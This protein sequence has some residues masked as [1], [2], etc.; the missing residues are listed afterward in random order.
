M[1]LKWFSFGFLL[2]EWIARLLQEVK[3]NGKLKVSV[4][5][6]IKEC[7]SSTANWKTT[8]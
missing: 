4:R 3:E 5:G 1:D 2:N 6:K 7:V 8:D